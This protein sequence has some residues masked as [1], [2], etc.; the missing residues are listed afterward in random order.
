M[1]LTSG[2]NVEIR[3]NNTLYEG[4]SELIGKFKTDEWNYDNDSRVVSVSIKDDLE[5]WQDINVEEILYNPHKPIEKNFEWLY[6]ELYLK[7]IENGNYEML[8]FEQLEEQTKWILSNTYIKYPMLKSDSLWNCWNKL[9]KVCQLHIY[10]NSEGI[11][12][13]RYNGGN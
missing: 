8:S 7:T 3:L 12:V 9:C 4:K 10:K 6:K 1:I 2:L 13:C 5:E 11:V